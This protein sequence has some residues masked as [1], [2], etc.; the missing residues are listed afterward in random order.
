MADHRQEGWIRPVTGEVKCNVDATIFKDQD[1]Y[2]VSVSLRGDQQ[3]FIGG[4]ATW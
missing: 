4:K 2:G 3:E 1:C